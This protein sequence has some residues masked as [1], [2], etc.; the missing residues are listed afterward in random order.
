MIYHTIGTV[1]F[2]SPV[3]VD[4]GHQVEVVLV[5]DV[6]VRA[7]ILEQSVGDVGH[8]RRADPLPWQDNKA[9]DMNL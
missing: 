6:E 2:F 7:R 3:R 4:E 1:S 5:E 9:T 8:G